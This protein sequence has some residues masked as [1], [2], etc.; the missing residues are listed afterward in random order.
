M[1]SNLIARN[2]RRSR[3]ENGIFFVSLVVTVIAFY[4]IL[5]LENQDVMVFL[6]RMESDAVQRLLGLVPALYAFTLVVL[7]FLVFFAERYQLE[8]RR[9]ELGMYL[10]LGMRRSRL[11]GML[12]AE[13]LRT[14]LIALAIGLPVGLLI[15][16]V[17]SLVSVR[18]VGLGVLGHQVTLSVK[19]LVL[20]VVGFAGIKLLVSLILSG[21]IARTEI[22]SL[23]APAPEGTKRRLPLAVYAIALVLG[24]AMLAGAYALGIKGHAWMGPVFMALML[25]LGLLGT[26]LVFFG[27]RVVVG[28][29]AKRGGK[30]LATFNYRQVE[31]TVVH[32][33]GTLAICSVLILV[34]LVCFGTGVS[35]AR[36]HKAE[37]HTL[38]YT[39][40]LS[41]GLEVPT[42]DQLRQQLADAGLEGL[43]AELFDMRVGVIR[44]VEEGDA[45][46]W[47][48]VISLVQAAKDSGAKESLLMTLSHYGFP[49]TVSV[50]GYNELLA[51][52]G[53]P[54]ITLAPSEVA[55]Y[56][57]PELTDAG[58]QTLLEAVLAQHPTILIAGEAYTLTDGLQTR[59]LV[60]DRSFTPQ[61]ALILPDAAFETFAE[62]QWDTYVN[63]VL[64]S[65]TI[66][67]RPTMMVYQEVN[68]KLD[69]AGIPYE[70][71]LQNMGRELFYTVA[72]SD[73]TI[74]LAIIFLVVANTLIGVLFLM[75]QRR[76]SRR[77]R[78]LVRLGA[79]FEDLCHAVGTQVNWFF[80]LPVGVAVLSSAFG[81]RAMFSG[82]LSSRAQAGIPDLMVSAGAMIVLLALVEV[83]YMV[84]VK[85]AGNRYLLELMEPEREE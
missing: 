30:G 66:A 45:V 67:G 71:Y 79:G 63:G 36:S 53:L 40:D 29:L 4:I 70:S 72:A 18:L 31:E 33:S 44:V 61:M 11:F 56:A 60:T 15:S 75:G 43:F 28:W 84:A 26:A 81:I 46:D 58:R 51:V 39:F 14:S 20:T 65:E 80:G 21:L 3:R 1:S 55:L 41:M 10:M 54:Q 42:S 16:E 77:Y 27:L 19:A 35:I 62:G 5:S 50:S 64:S 74:Y 9:H 32:R 23:L 85:R 22:G 13:D 52:A 57:D 25:F 8:Q 83:V 76:A 82:V 34:A 68:D 17:I 38:D 48:E 59:A 73:L 24:L 78:T 7:F 49:N 12:V 69:A 47:S 6:Q 37:T 2:S